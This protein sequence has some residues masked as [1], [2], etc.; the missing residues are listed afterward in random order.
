MYHCGPDLK[1]EA[2]VKKLGVGYARYQMAWFLNCRVAG[3]GGN[4][5][6][7]L[8]HYLQKISGVLFRT[9]IVSFRTDFGQKFRT[10]LKHSL[11]KFIS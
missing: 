3:G 1:E 2:S 9:F 10:L 5:R 4:Y 6:E 7:N 8:V 11:S